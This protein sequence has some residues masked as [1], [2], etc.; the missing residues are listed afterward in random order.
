MSWGRAFSAALALLALAL[1][2]LIYVLHIRWLGFPDGHLTEYDRAERLLYW[3]AIWPCLG[4]AGYWASRLHPR[5]APRKT[6]NYMISI[7]IF[8]FYGVLVGAIQQLMSHYLDSG[9]GG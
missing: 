4:F 1:P 8:V 3:I 6:L 2:A 7:V 5:T 9:Q